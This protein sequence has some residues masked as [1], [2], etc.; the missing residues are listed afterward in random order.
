MP[1]FSD[2]ALEEVVYVMFDLW[3][4]YLK[5]QKNFVIQEPILPSFGRQFDF[6]NLDLLAQKEPKFDISQD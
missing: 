6:E 3:E 1:I 5:F 2:E 4:S